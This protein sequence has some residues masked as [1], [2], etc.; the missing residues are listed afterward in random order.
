VTEIQQQQQQKKTAHKNCDSL[1]FFLI[2]CRGQSHPS[3]SDYLNLCVHRPNS[4]IFVHRQ[5]AFQFP[6][7]FIYACQFQ[8][9]KMGQSQNYTRKPLYRCISSLYQYT[10]C[11]IHIYICMY[12]YDNIYI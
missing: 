2:D 3:G 8:G 11:I 12:I 4:M 1:I 10:V 6:I 5:V 7:V 9:G